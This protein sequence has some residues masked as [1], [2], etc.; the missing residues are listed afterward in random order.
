[1]RG[2]WSTAWADAELLRALTG[3]VP[4]TDIREGVQ[5]FVEWYRD[6]YQK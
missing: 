5:R 1:M 2:A 3:Y 4:N 6:F